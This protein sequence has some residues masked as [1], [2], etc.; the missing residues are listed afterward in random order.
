[1]TNQYLNKLE[2]GDTIVEAKEH[3]EFYRSYAFNAFSR[4]VSKIEGAIVPQKH[5]IIGTA[6]CNMAVKFVRFGLLLQ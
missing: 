1:M 3:K 6:G 2:E 5:R 4:C